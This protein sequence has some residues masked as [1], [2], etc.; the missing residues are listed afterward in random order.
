MII[1]KLFNCIIPNIEKWEF[2]CN[3]ISNPAIFG[4]VDKILPGKSGVQ[5]NSV[6]FQMFLFC[7]ISYA[8]S[9]VDNYAHI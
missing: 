1:P 2:N 5:F 4:I 3:F 9:F 6:F 8:P 7:T